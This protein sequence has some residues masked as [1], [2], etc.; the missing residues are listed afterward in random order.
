MT[1]HVVN[2]EQ[3]FMDHLNASQHPDQASTQQAT[4]E[5]VAPPEAVA[6]APEAPSAKSPEL[7]R[8][9]AEEAEA[10]AARQEVE[11]IKRDMAMLVAGYNAG[12]RR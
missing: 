4:P 3:M 1:L 5:P 6:P 8:A 12:Q 10:R 2:F 11:A 7:I 9:E